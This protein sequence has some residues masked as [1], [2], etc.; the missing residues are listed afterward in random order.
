MQP[1]AHRA[2]RVRPRALDELGVHQR[3]QLVVALQVRHAEQRARRPR[4]DVG[5]RQQPER[6]QQAALRAAAVVVAEREARADALVDLPRGLQLVQPAAALVLEPVGHRA[7]RPGLAG[8][9]PPAADPDGQRQVPAQVGDLGRRVRVGEDP[10]PA[11]QQPEQLDGVGGAELRQP[12]VEGAA[13]VQ[14][15]PRGHQHHAAAARRQQRLHLVAVAGVVQQDEQAQA[16]RPRPPQLLQLRQAAGVGRQPHAQRLEEP[17]QH[18]L[19]ADPRVPRAAQVEV[20]APVRIVV[21][22]LVREPGGQRRLAHPRRPVQRHHQRRRGRGG[23]VRDGAAQRVQR[24]A[25]AGEV[26]DD[27]RELR[28]RPPGD[29][30]PAAPVPRA[31]RL[32][33]PG[34]HPG[35]RGDAAGHHELR[36]AGQLQR[37]QRGRD[38]RDHRGEEPH[39]A[40][41]RQPRAAAALPGRAGRPRPGA[42]RSVRHPRPSASLRVPPRPPPRDAP[43]RH[44][45]P[46]R[47]RHQGQISPFSHDLARYGEM[48]ERQGN[49]G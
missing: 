40:R 37:V 1:V 24:L 30:P 31:R 42:G 39:D 48:S 17:D 46:P 43:A 8:R 21:G 2:R 12:P 18:L 33:G 29:L 5:H 4:L 25:A 22:D 23:A 27:R 32:R 47:S 10:L 49:G 45:G 26:R 16:A 3:L 34:R 36:G 11:R 7:R 13:Q 38:P 20:E 19:R 15:L 9:Q 35:E 28:R 14:R 41:R 44:P 6:A